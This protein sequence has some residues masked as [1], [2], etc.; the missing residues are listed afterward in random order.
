MVSTSRH[1]RGLILISSCC[2]SPEL[3]PAKTW[4]FEHG[5]ICIWLAPNQQD[6]KPASWPISSH[7]SCCNIA[8]KS[9]AV[10]DD[11]SLSL[12]LV[13]RHKCFAPPCPHTGLLLSFLVSTAQPTEDLKTLCLSEVLPSRA[14]LDMV[15]N[16]PCMPPDIHCHVWCVVLI[17]SRTSLSLPACAS[18]VLKQKLP[19]IYGM[20]MMCLIFVCSV[21]TFNACNLLWSTNRLA[22]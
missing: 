11:T 12:S 19:C 18:C 10:G 7:S 9:W 3:L 13:H 1:V 2:L 21:G 15:L 22:Q 20:G 4:L 8:I 6:R 14:A 5:F 17:S 16:N